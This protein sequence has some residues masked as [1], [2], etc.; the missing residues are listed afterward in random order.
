MTSVG[1]G[2]GGGVGVA[3]APSSME[4]TMTKAIKIYRVFLIVIFLL[5]EIFG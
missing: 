1:G 4:A 5:I 2:G 3:Q